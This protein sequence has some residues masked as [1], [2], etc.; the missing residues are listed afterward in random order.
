MNEKQL[1]VQANDGVA[2]FLVIDG[3][4][5]INPEQSLAITYAGSS[6]IITVKTAAKALAVL[7]L[8]TVD[9]I[10]HDMKNVDDPTLNRIKSVAAWVQPNIHIVNAS[11]REM[12]FT[13]WRKKAP[14]LFRTS[15]AAIAGI[16]AQDAV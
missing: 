10:F 14:H 3:S 4:A 6:V 13:G 7:Q 8:V 11:A 2:V 9:A 12:N 1:N 16:I 5:S 15:S